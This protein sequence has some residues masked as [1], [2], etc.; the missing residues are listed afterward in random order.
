MKSLTEGIRFFVHSVLSSF[1]EHLPCSDRFVCQRHAVELQ[2]FIL[3]ILQFFRE[4]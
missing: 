3:W 2:A 4:D 1:V